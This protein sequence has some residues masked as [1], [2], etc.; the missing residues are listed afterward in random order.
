M[1]MEPIN[2]NQLKPYI[3]A[4][5]GL[6]HEGDIDLCK[7]MIWEAKK[8]GCNAV[9]I[10]SLDYNDSN[11]SKNLEAM[12]ETKRYGNISVGDLLKKLLLSDEETQEFADHCKEVKIDFISTPFGFRH[13][14]LLD[15][16]GIDKYK[17]ASMD[18]IHLKFL[19]EIAKKQK[20][21]IVSVGMGTIGEIERAIETIRKFNSKELSLLYCVAQYPPEDSEMNLKRILTLKNIF[22]VKIGFSDHTIGITAAIIAT[23]LGADIIEK[24]F[25]YDKTAEGWDHAISAD[26]EEMK[27]LCA[28]TRRA[29][30]MLGDTFWNIPKSELLQRDKI[31]RS[32]VSKTNLQEGDILTIDNIDFKRPGIGIRPD[33]MGYMLGR[34]INKNIE[35]DEL[36]YWK[37]LT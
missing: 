26:Y 18:L 35:V 25:T 37:D 28:E 31:R 20:P 11:I 12:T 36:I 1:N 5:L 30:L 2:L 29:R 32:I 13:I 17:I 9:K 34:R 14:D 33:E 6:N 24:H 15:K 7:E 19:E 27:L 3:V 10:Q 4:E 16:M 22:D 8:A 23:T 21:M